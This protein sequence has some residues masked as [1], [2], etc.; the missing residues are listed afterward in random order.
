MHLQNPPNPFQHFL[1]FS[2]IYITKYSCLGHIYTCWIPLWNP[3]N[4]VKAHLKNIP[5]TSSKP[6]TFV[7]PDLNFQKYCITKFQI[8]Q[9]FGLVK[10][11]ILLYASIGENP[12]S[13]AL[14]LLV[15]FLPKQFLHFKNLNLFSLQSCKFAKTLV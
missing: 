9:N 4:I 10:C 3:Y 7:S 15:Q 5:K 11:P 8:M 6:S 13:F 1:N 2:N 12:N 14:H